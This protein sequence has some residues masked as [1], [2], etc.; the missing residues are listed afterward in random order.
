MNFL[1][2]HYLAIINFSLILIIGVFVIF[3][4]NTPNTYAV[5]DK[6]KLFNEFKMTKDVSNEISIANNG[7]KVQYDSINYIYNNTRDLGEREVI[8][9]R[10]QSLQMEIENLNLNYREQETVKIWKRIQSYSSQYLDKENYSIIL[11][12]ENNGD[13]LGFKSE[14]NITDELLLYINKRYEGIN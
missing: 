8:A 11:G 2:I 6:I 13:V 14:L 7:F 9:K 12:A 1:R 4:E 5:V 10:L 3:K